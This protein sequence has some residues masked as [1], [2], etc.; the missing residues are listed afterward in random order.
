MRFSHSNI[1]T[2]I[3]NPNMDLTRVILMPCALYDKT[4]GTHT[5]RMAS[6]LHGLDPH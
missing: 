4:L 2:F 3:L 6:R 5:V 1:S